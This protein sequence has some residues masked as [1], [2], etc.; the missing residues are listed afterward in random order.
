[1]G[2]LQG[3]A[4]ARLCPACG[5]ANPLDL[6]KKCVRCRKALPLYCFGCYEPIAGEK[7]ARCPGCGRGRWVVGDHADMPCVA[8]AG[9]PTRSQRYMTTRVRAKKI[10]HEWRCMK[11][12]AEDTLTDPFRHFPDRKEAVA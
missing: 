11:C 10:V 3:A 2:D 7:E 1:M 9:H 8:E 6:S 12:F 4:S 5:A